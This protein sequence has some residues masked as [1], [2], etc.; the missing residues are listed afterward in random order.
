MS[1][2]YGFFDAKNRD[3]VYTAENFTEYLSSLICNGVLDTYGQCFS[4]T[5]NNN[6]T[7]T[8]GTG[9]AWINGHYFENDAPYSLDLSSHVS[10]SENR[11]AV[12][13]ICCNTDTN[14]R[15]CSIA[16]A[17]G[18]TLPALS[19]FGTQSYITLASVYLAAGTT[20]ITSSDITDC[21]DDESKC[22]YVKCILGKCGISQ[23]AAKLDALEKRAV[24]IEKVLGLDS[25]STH[26]I[27]A[28]GT[29]ANGG[30]STIDHM[31]RIMNGLMGTIGLLETVKLEAD[32]N[33]KNN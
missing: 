31:D 19:D 21:R 12:I 3:R 23:L 8:I 1:F 6:L 14:V 32:N 22:G 26:P 17:A 11:Y 25:T 27:I 13:G 9:K 20:V 2:S 7:V 15:E 16:V 33:D 30:L 24:T 28:F 5:A 18:A 4:I 29:S 10:Q